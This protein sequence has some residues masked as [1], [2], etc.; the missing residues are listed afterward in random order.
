MCLSLTPR[1]YKETLVREAFM[2]DNLRRQKSI[3]WYEADDGFCMSEGLPDATKDYAHLMVTSKFAEGDLKS[4][5]TCR[6]NFSL[7]RMCNVLVECDPPTA[8]MCCMSIGIERRVAVNAGD[9]MVSEILLRKQ[10]LQLHNRSSMHVKGNARTFAFML[11]WSNKAGASITLESSV[12]GMY[13]HMIPQAGL[14]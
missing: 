12:P 13:W 11:P 5:V 8:S 3:C 4:A 1:D 9:G 7:N 2:V 14:H 6:F 10:V